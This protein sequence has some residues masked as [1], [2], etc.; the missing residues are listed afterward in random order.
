MDNIFKVLYHNQYQ[1]LEVQKSKTKCCKL[2]LSQ[3]NNTFNVVAGIVDTEVETN[4]NVAI[5]AIKINR[6]FFVSS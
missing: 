6:L 4:E 1:G 5:K 3:T 2:K